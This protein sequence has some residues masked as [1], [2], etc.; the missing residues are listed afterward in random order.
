MIKRLPLFKQEI[1]KFSSEGMFHKNAL[2]LVNC[3][4]CHCFCKN[5]CCIKSVGFI[6]GI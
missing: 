5:V 2:M 1:A 6:Y 3:F 4:A